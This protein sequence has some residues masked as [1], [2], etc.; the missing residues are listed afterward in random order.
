M[1][2]AAARNQT[3]RRGVTLVVIG[4]DYGKTFPRK[5]FKSTTGRDNNT[6][7][8]NEFILALRVHGKCGPKKL[9]GGLEI[10]KVS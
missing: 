1:K 10:P 5:T 9:V 6:P 8:S 7:R 2:L 4:R 3:S